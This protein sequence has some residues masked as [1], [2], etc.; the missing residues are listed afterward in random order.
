[1][2]LPGVGTRADRLARVLDDP[3]AAAGEPELTGLVAVAERLRSVEDGEPD[4][5][6]RTQLRNRLVTAA[7]DASVMRAAAAGR[8]LD[9]DELAARRRRWTGPRAVLVAALLVLVALASL[10]VVFSRGALPGD[11]LYGV[12]RASEDAELQFARGDEARGRRY[13]GMART[14]AEE[15][16]DL[17]GK[18]VNS[19]TYTSTLA[20]MDAQTKDG[21]KLLNGVAAGRGDDGLLLREQTWAVDQYGILLGLVGRLPVPAQPDAVDSMVLLR[22]VVERIVLLRAGL[23][24]DCLGSSGADDLGPLPCGPCAARTGSTPPSAATTTPSVPTSTPRPGAP[25]SSR[26]VPPSTAP[27]STGGGAGGSAPPTSGGGGGAP[28]PTGGGGGGGGGPLPTSVPIPSVPGLPLP[29]TVPLPPLPSLPLPS[30]PS[31][32]LPSLPLPSLPLPTG[33]VPTGLLPGG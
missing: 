31:L 10:T 25:G 17:T 18:Q 20:T 21:S 27:P 9:D 33:L 4:P 11:S 22:R 15:I 12:K 28:A 23:G 19:G 1:M 8:A 7:G 32:P 16:R 14:R 30:L 29:T 6:F 5:R 13:L 3:P 26:P 2:R 24:C